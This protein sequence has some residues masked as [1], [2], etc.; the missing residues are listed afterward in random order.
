MDR[1]PLPTWVHPK[2]RLVLLG[3]ACHPM[4]VR[5]N[6]SSFLSFLS[7]ATRWHLL[8]DQSLPQPYRAQGAAIAVEDAAV[9]GAILSHVSS[10][11][12]VPALLQAY[13]DLRCVLLLRIPPS[14]LPSLPL[15]RKST[16][17]T[18]TAGY[19]A[20]LQRRTPRG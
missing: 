10:L 9:L 16:H 20:R 5:V 17:R 18:D 3:D 1:K 15:T 2:G 6:T 13:Q 12:Q 11:A 7:T 14:I 4:L 8:T 19:R